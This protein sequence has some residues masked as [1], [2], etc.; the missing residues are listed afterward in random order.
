VIRTLA[1]TTLVALVGCGHRPP[2]PPDPVPDAALLVL[3]RTLPAEGAIPADEAFPLDAEGTRWLSAS[4]TDPK[5]IEAKPVLVTVRGSDAHG[6]EFE[7]E[8]P[9]EAV[10][11]LSRGPDGIDL[12]AVLSPSDAA[13][14]IFAMPLRLLPPSLEAGGEHRASAAMDVVDAGDPSRRKDRGTGERVA[15]YTHDVEITLAGRTMRARVLE[16]T[17]TARLRSATATRTVELLVV[18]GLGPV[19]ERWRRE[20]LVLGLVR[21][22]REGVRVREL[23]ASE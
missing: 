4:G 20:V 5:A 15:R 14:S 3:G 16:S 2:P 12:H 1:V 8:V 10:E 17:F 18:P 13:L 21:T 9:G 11:F 22:V 23:H 19:A 7:R 6:G